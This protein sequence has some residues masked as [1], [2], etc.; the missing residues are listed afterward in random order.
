M[1]EI[2]K[3]EV[4]ENDK[5]SYRIELVKASQDRFFVSIEQIIYS[6]TTETKSQIKIRATTLEGIIDTLIR[7]QAEIPKDPPKR[8]F[9]THGRKQELIN[10]YLNKNLEIET[11]AV[12]FDCSVQQVEQLLFDENIFVVSNKIPKEKSRRFW[13]GK[14]K[15]GK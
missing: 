13:S 10:R 5:S 14:K 15:S 2:I 12:Q 6:L 4:I 9:L 3:V 8:G 7:F 11:L 1:D